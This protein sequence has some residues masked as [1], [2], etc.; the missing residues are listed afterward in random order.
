MSEV[1]VIIATA[2]I[3]PGVESLIIKGKCG[4][5]ATEQHNK[6]WRRLPSGGWSSPQW[7]VKNKVVQYS[8]ENAF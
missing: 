3:M 6:S 1:H 7:P 4:V 8:N 5:E 2:I